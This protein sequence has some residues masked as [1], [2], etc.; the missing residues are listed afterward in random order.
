M[1]EIRK[2]A[3]AFAAS[4]AHETY[5]KGESQTFWNEFLQIFGIDRRRVASFEKRAQRFSRGNQGFIDLFWP[6]MLLV[7]QKSAV[8][9]MS[10][11]L[12]G[13]P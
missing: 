9:L 11:S 5:E 4:W 12:R 13:G 7:E 1:N 10:L 6:G 3:A 8:R 2:R